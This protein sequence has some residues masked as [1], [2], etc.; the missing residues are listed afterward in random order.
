MSRTYMQDKTDWLA[1]LYLWLQ[2][3]RHQKFLPADGGLMLAYIAR[4]TSPI[5]QKLDPTGRMFVM[6][7]MYP[8]QTAPVSP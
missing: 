4:M 3:D 2:H 6:V 1:T 7:C 5:A 8:V